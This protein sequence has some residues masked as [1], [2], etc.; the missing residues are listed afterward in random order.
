MNAKFSKPAVPGLSAPARQSRIA[1]K[2]DADTAPDPK[3]RIRRAILT[4]PILST[5]L[6][7]SVPTTL[8]TWPRTAYYSG[9]A[10]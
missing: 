10:E 6:E 1:R 7:L 3:A 9:A 4:G 8:L 5:M 2:S